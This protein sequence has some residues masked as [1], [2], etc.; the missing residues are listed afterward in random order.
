MCSWGHEAK[1][2]SACSHEWRARSNV[3]LIFSTKAWHG[4]RERERER[5]KEKRSSSGH[6]RK[7]QGV[8]QSATNTGRWNRR[9]EPGGLAV[10]RP[11]YWTIVLYFEQFAGKCHM[12]RVARTWRRPCVFVADPPANAVHEATALRTWV[13]LQ[14]SLHDT[15]AASRSTWPEPWIIELGALSSPA[16]RT[17]SPP[18]GRFCW[19]SER[20]PAKRRNMRTGCYFNSCSHSRGFVS[21]WLEG[22]SVRWSSLKCT[23]GMRAGWLDSFR[24]QGH[25]NTH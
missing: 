18:S 6:S 11:T 15:K 20:P 9:R 2:S 12:E 25:T 13:K 8:V 5:K 22:F 10:C 7:C 16:S 1:N 19:R 3:A 17:S 24:D 14:L 4:G 21:I 23:V